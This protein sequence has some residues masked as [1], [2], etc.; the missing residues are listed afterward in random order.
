ME[1]AK[2]QMRNSGKA[3]LGLLLQHEEAETSTGALVHPPGGRGLSWPLKWDECGTDWWARLKGWIGCSAHP[4]VGAACR[5]HAQ[6]PTF[7]SSTSEAAVGFW[8][9]CILLFII[10]PHCACTQLLLVPWSFFV[11]LP[12]WLR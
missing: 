1:I 12:W 5:D 11:G 8:P 9:F 4:C 2:G 3:F 7:A 6:D 10:C